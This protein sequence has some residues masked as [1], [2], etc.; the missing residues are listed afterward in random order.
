MYTLKTRLQSQRACFIEDV[1]HHWS[2]DRPVPFWAD[3]LQSL[4]MQIFFPVKRDLNAIQLTTKTTKSPLFC[5]GRQKKKNR[6]TES[7][8]WEAL[9]VQKLVLYIKVTQWHLTLQPTKRLSKN[10]AMT[11][12]KKNYIQPSAKKKL[13][14]FWNTMIAFVLWFLTKRRGPQISLDLR[15]GLFSIPGFSIPQ[16]V[17]IFI[18]SFVIFF[19]CRLIVIPWEKPYHRSSK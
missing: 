8:H 1:Q 10:K 5:V 18:T 7:D 15:S 16:F 11:G 9:Q 14:E 3:L 12:K 6:N 2:S 4:L 17:Y 19:N 13:A